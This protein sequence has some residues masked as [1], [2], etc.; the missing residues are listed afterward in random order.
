M[1]ITSR[2]ST[3]TTSSNSR[4]ANEDRGLFI[5]RREEGSSG[6]IRPVTVGSEYAVGT[7]TTGMDGTFGNLLIQVVSVN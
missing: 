5:L 6:D 1:D 2:V 3:S 4:E 7:D